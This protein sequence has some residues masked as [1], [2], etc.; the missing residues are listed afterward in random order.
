M[1]AKAILE[2]FEKSSRNFKLNLGLFKHSCFN[3]CQK[4]LQRE[5]GK[6]LTQSLYDEHEDFNFH[7]TN[8]PFLSSNILSLPAYGVFISQLI[9]YAR[10]CSSYLCFILRVVRIS[11]KPLGQVY[12]KERL[13]SSL[14]KFYD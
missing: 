6:D 1:D 12:V 14:R 2:C 9:R 13:N 10:A 5:T 8:F 3:P 7:F 11:N 4:I